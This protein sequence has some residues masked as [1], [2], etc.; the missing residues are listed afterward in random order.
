MGAVNELKKA[1][2]GLNLEEVK[3]FGPASEINWSFCPADA[4]WQ[5][6]STEAL[7]KSVKRALNV[8]M[9]GKICSFAEMQTVMHEAVQLVNQRPIGRKPLTPDDGTYL[10]PNDLLLGHYYPQG[11]FSESANAKQRLN[12][13]QDIIKKFWEKW[14]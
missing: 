10:C 4:P 14:T 7:V 9:A 3:A 5:N 11:P 8:V 12:F 6:G 1:I 13:T 2:A